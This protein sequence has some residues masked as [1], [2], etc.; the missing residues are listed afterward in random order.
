[1]MHRF[2]PSPSQKEKAERLC[3]RIQEELGSSLPPRAEPAPPP[4]CRS[5]FPVALKRAA[6]AVD[7]A[8]VKAE[9]DPAYQDEFEKAKDHFEHV[10][11]AMSEQKKQKLRGPA[12]LTN[13]NYV[14]G[15][16]VRSNAW[17]ARRMATA[18]ATTTPP[19]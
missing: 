12:I 7:K 19:Q 2:K 17:Y 18:Q 16:S 6:V 9:N 4:L 5:Q 1:M 8:K 13:M 11:E 15:D 3:R 14:W 10:F